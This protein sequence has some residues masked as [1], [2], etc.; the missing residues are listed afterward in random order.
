MRQN[1]E[2]KESK[3]QETRI[4]HIILKSSAFT[5][6]DIKIYSDLEF[7]KGKLAIFVQRVLYEDMYF[8]K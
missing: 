8:E 6:D 1:A 4:Q 2:I 7:F 3:I 5:A